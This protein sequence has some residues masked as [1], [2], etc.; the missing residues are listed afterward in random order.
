MNGK[1]NRIFLA[2]ILILII[3]PFFLVPDF[4]FGNDHLVDSWKYFGLNYQF[5]DFGKLFFSYMD[6]RLPILLF[7]GFMFKY[8]DLKTAIYLR[9]F[10]TTILCIT[11]LYL[12]I[13]NIFGEST[14][15]IISVLFLCNPLFYGLQSIDYPSIGVD[16][17]IFSSFFILTLDKYENNK[18][19]IIFASF[20]F[21]CGIFSNFRSII[22]YSWIPFVYLLNLNHNSNRLKFIYHSILGLI[23]FIIFFG[24][25]NKLLGRP[26]FFFYDQLFHLKNINEGSYNPGLNIRL[27]QNPIPQALSIFIGVYLSLW[28]HKNKKEYSFINNGFIFFLIVIFTLIVI[29]FNYFETTSVHWGFLIFYLIMGAVIT[30]LK[31]KYNFLILGIS[32]I[33][34]LICFTQTPGY[35]RVLYDELGNVYPIILIISFFLL[36]FASLKF[37]KLNYIYLSLFFLIISNLRPDQFG[38]AHF[39][40]SPSASSKSEYEIIEKATKTLSKFMNSYRPLFLLDNE[41]EIYDKIRLSV[42]GGFWDSRFHL[43][44]FK[45]S[46]IVLHNYTVI[47]NKPINKFPNDILNYLEFKQVKAT[48]LEKIKINDLNFWVYK[49][50]PD[51]E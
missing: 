4:L 18:K 41:S 29:S 26:F 48:F 42:S 38:E 33:S 46:G 12:S 24:L 23:I 43:N 3:I 19:F 6:D 17:Y 35:F 15:K 8:L 34:I 37:Q 50:I 20:L 9:Y 7:N 30:E 11:V 32:F 22:Y 1:I 39:F 40:K 16:I 14:A 45:N 13:K 51:Q 36:T 44:S 5:L 28:L 47:T 2:N 49:F 27:R 21:C 10:L 25:I 31:V